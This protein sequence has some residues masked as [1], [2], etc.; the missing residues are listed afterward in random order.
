MDN[1]QGISLLITPPVFRKTAVDHLHDVASLT[2]TRRGDDPQAGWEHSADSSLYE[3]SPALFEIRNYPLEDH[4]DNV[5]RGREEKN[6]SWWRRL[7][8]LTHSTGDPHECARRKNM[9]VSREELAKLVAKIKNTPASTERD[10]DQ[11]L[12]QSTLPGLE[13]LLAQDK[14]EYYYS[15][16]Y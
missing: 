4:F 9:P 10:I 6:K 12:L 7:L 8:G 16:G 1:M 14:G 13:K 15:A 2:Q 11:E 3:G 5:A